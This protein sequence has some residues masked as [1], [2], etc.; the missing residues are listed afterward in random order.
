MIARRSSFRLPLA[1]PLRTAT[2]GIDERRGW[3][4]E[5]GDEPPG[6]GEAT[7][8]PGFTESLAACDAALETAVAALRQDDW[9]AAFAA[10][11]DAPA[12]RT[13]LATAA[14]DRRASDAGDPLYRYL[15]GDR[16]ETIPVNATIGDGTVDATVAA[17]MG[18]VDEGFATL[19]VKV[20]ARSVDEDV[21]RARAVRTAVGDGVSLRLDANGAWSLAQA[22][23]ALDDL[24]GLAL[25]YVEQPLAA[26]RLE[27][28]RR[29]RGD[30]PIALDESLP[31]RNPHEVVAGDYAD[32]L[33][34]KPMALGGPDVARGVAHAAGRAGLD[35]VVSNTVDAVVGRTAAVHVAASLDEPRAAGLVTGDLLSR[36]LGA[37]PAPVERGRMTVPQSPGLG[38]G[39]VRVDA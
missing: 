33:V 15:G 34:L 8:L 36:D 27:E 26:D 7:P 35:V 32:V 25:E 30:V 17:A 38:V 19:K 3:L 2:G 9:P 11:T 37:D 24:A 13:A 39:E 28:T 14:L 5:I 21:E 12:A 22:R 6:I 23:A 16:R 4:L 31:A 29:L 18:A 1:T 10:V 20:G